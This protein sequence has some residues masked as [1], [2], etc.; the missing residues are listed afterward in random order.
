MRTEK[1][2]HTL[3]VAFT[4]NMKKEKIGPRH[5]C[6]GYS[7]PGVWSEH[8]ADNTNSLAWATLWHEVCTSRSTWR[9]Y[10]GK[11]K[12]EILQWKM[13]EWAFKT[14]QALWGMG[15]QLLRPWTVANSNGPWM[16]VIGSHQNRH[17]PW[18]RW[19]QPE[20]FY[21]NLMW[22]HSK[23]HRTENLI[24]KAKLL[25][26]PLTSP[27][28]VNLPNPLL[29]MLEWCVQGR[30]WFK[31]NERNHETVGWTLAR[32]HVTWDRAED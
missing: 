32:K 17:L 22:I 8:C 3:E 19:K 25:K 1:H 13:S 15:L 26:Q 10:V 2:C 28:Q 7:L 9:E 18:G 30:S 12:R 27:S 11:P 14:S 24:K 16:K 31:V 4:I 5:F 6:Q 23:N 21:R 29:G 20:E